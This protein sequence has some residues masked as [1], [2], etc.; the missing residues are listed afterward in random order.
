MSY[1]YETEKHAIEAIQ[2]SANGLG[3]IVD[4][5]GEPD[6]VFVRDNTVDL[7]DPW[8]R[9]FT[10]SSRWRSLDLYVHE[11]SDGHCDFTIERKQIKGGGDGLESGQ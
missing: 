1:V 5:L 10:Y 3:G 6:D 7:V 8:M 9:Q 11:Y 2:R 4:L